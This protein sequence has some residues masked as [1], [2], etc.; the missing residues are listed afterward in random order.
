MRRFL[1][2][3]CAFL[4][5]ASVAPAV[6]HQ[7]GTLEA[8]Y[9]IEVLSSTPEATT[10][11]FEVGGF[12]LRD[13]D[14]NG[15]VHSAV[16]WDGGATLQVRGE[17]ALPQFHESIVIPDDAEMGLRVV[18]A[19]YVELENVRIAPSKG[20]I[21]RD[22]LPETVSWELGDV[23]QR[24]AW[25][26]AEI[27]TL[28]EPYILRDVRGAVVN[29]SPFQWNPVT[30]TLRVATKIVVEA[31]VTGPGRVNVLTRRPAELASEFETI[32]RDHFLNYGGALRYQSV[33]EIGNMLVI[34]YDAFE[35]ATQPLVDWKNQVGIETEMVRMSDVGSTAS[36]LLSYVQGYY[37]AN[38]VCFIL[39]VGDG[40]Q[41]P[42]LTNGGGAADPRLTLLAGSDSYP[43]C[44]IGR[45]SAQNV[46]QVSSQVERIVEYERDPDPSAT[47][48][49]KA[50]A[51]ASNEGA[52]YGDD[53]EA[54]WE[55]ARNYREDLLGFTYSQV[56]ELYDGTH[57]GGGGGMGGGGGQEDQDG[58]PTSADVVDLVNGGRGLIHYTGHGSTTSWSTTGFGI[59]HINQL[60]NDNMLPMVVS[61]G[62]VNGAFMYTTC[63]AEAWVQATSGGEPS[64]A[65]A[66]YASTVNQQ[67]AT[68]MRAQDEMIDLL[69]QNQKRTWGGLCFNGSCDMIDHYGANGISEF[70]NWTLFGDPSIRLRTATPSVIAVSHAGVVNSDENQFVV[71]TEPKAMVALSHEGLL[72][73]AA[74]AD[75]AGNATVSFDGGELQSLGSVTLTVTSFNGIPNV[76]SVPVNTTTTAVVRGGGAVELR[77][78][79]PNPFGPTTQISFALPQEGAATL[80]IFDVAGRKVRTLESGTLPAGNHQVIW[81]GT[82]PLGR[83]LGAGSY[84]YRLTVG[85]RVETRRM[86]LLR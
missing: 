12:E 62:C 38:G 84:F 65:V 6:E 42:Y 8:P 2:Y 21:T 64:G 18:S 80:E 66:C 60:V 47:W 1:A 83:K 58:N 61:V 29:V 27:A 53:G 14:V 56:H 77:Q 30:E 68:P 23:Y 13:V 67:W 50:I 78:N 19:E 26:P 86:V 46:A 7:V 76:G 59:S 9:R 25:Y 51:I 44:F 79:H 5:L 32:Y 48:Y 33:G 52:G 57:P 75:G 85:D 17:P 69:C 11:Q 49:S 37:D 3:P 70:K 55:H 81:D 20:P 16:S 39:L 73:G 15:A 36:D 4:L 10:V 54:D 40:P 71:Q 24:D 34:V 31:S 22:V 43:D 35:A 41:I 72:F 28:G 45:I 63:F 82:G 74:I